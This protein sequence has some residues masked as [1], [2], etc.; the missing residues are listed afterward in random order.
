MDM[1]NNADALPTCPQLQQKQQQTADRNWLKLT[2]TTAR[3]RFNRIP[4]EDRHELMG[5]RPVVCGDG[6][7]CFAQTVRRTVVQLSLIAP[8]AELV[9]E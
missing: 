4:T 5:A 8:V 1:M 2:H 3:R 7:A 6:R 9:A